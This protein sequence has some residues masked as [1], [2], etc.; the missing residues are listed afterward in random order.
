MNRQPSSPAGP[1]AWAGLRPQG[2]QIGRPQRAAHRSSSCPAGFFQNRKRIVNP[3]PPPSRRSRPSVG[4]GHCRVG[5]GFRLIATG[6]H[7]P[8]P[9]FL[10]G[11]SRE[12][13]LSR[14]GNVLPCDPLPAD[15]ANSLGFCWEWPSRALLC[16]GTA[17]APRRPASGA[18]PHKSDP[19][20]RACLRS[21]AFVVGT[22][23]NSKTD[24]GRSGP[25]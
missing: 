7:M 2:F 18:R 4:T 25:A 17:G 21:V 9:R 14:G 23:D 11:P 15:S 1:D 24:P 22:A 20:W 8:P 13:P 5:L 19:G 3:A 16:A 6:R 12:Q 10:G